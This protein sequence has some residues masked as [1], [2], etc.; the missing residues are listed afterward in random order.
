MVGKAKGPATRE[1]A[2]RA[3]QELVVDGVQ[4]LH[5][6]LSRPASQRQLLSTTTSP[7]T[8]QSSTSRVRTGSVNP[9][10]ASQSGT[11]GAGSDEGFIPTLLGFRGRSGD[12]SGED[13]RFRWVFDA[14]VSGVFVSVNREEG[15]ERGGLLG[16]SGD[17]PFEAVLFDTMGL[18]A[19]TPHVDT[20]E[21]TLQTLYTILQ[22]SLE[23]K[24]QH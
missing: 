19:L 4:R 16:D 21:A 5:P 12:F 7:T 20:R 10:P 1:Y 15:M 3:L 18:F 11:T 17:D 2:V 6:N 22:V 23:L 13:E 24:S 9:P 8:P 14:D